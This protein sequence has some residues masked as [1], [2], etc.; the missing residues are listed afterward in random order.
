MENY[1]AL[2]SLQYDPPKR[3]RPQRSASKRLHDKIIWSAWTIAEGGDPLLRT[4]LLL[5]RGGRDDPLSMRSDA[6]NQ[7]RRGERSLS[8]S[9]LECLIARHPALATVVGWPMHLFDLHPLAQSQIHASMEAFVVEEEILPFHPPYV[10]Y[11]FHNDDARPFAPNRFPVPYLCCQYLYERGDAYG[12]LAIAAA[13]RL[14]HLRGDAN[15]LWDAGR[16]LVKALPGFCRE[17]SVRPH[18]DDAVALTENLLRLIPYSCRPL[19]IDQEILGQQINSMHHQPCREL[20]LEATKAGL[21]RDEPADP[22]ISFRSVVTR[23]NTGRK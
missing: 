5:R 6:F 3:G 13:F 22:I 17:P 14:H 19:Q 7:Y 11:R 10:V 16:Y 1:D 23:P 2:G 20:R 21:Q 15:G 4:R 8:R 12:F 9:K 18:A